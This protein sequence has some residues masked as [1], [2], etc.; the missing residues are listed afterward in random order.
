LELNWTTFILE[1]VNFL[2]L[3]WL[4]KHFLYVPV[5]KVVERRRAG[6]EEHME[7]AKQIQQE[8]ETLRSQYENRLD[9]W[10]SERQEARQ[11]LQRELDSERKRLFDELQQE[12]AAEKKKNE[13]LAEREIAEHRRECELQ[14]LEMGGEFVSRLLEGVASAE[15]EQRLIDLL[16][17]E[18]KVL[19]PA[20]RDALQEKER[21]D[22]K[23]KIAVVSA[24]PLEDK[25]KTRLRERFEDLLTGPLAFEWHED[26]K[27][28]A[29]VRITVGPWVI[30]ANLNDELKAF[31][32]LTHER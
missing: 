25:Y 29:G 19:P 17:D 18:L 11:R 28:I 30:H 32:A 14:A 2:V 27:L 9:D 4:L 24:Y 12:L 7:K 5:K 20:Q 22:R 6:I 13:V 16:L 21:G 31:A 3:V 1:I 23:L 8:A 10:E 26:R 15:M